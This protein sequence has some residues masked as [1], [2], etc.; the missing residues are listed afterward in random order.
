MGGGEE[1]EAAAGVFCRPPLSSGEG[2]DPP[3][4]ETGMI[5]NRSAGCLVTLLLAAMLAGCEAE[6][7]SRRDAHRIKAALVAEKQAQAP[8]P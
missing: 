2:A 7:A 4:R 6:L 5:R 8:W 1:S 3:H